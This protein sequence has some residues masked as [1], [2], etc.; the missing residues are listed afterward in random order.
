MNEVIIGIQVVLEGIRVDDVTWVKPI[1]KEK[2]NV[3]ILENTDKTT[4]HQNG[5]VRSDMGLV[6]QTS[7]GATRVVGDGSQKF[8]I[9]QITTSST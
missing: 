7:L 8:P 4:E 5:E 9:T 3:R 1:R 2:L 6:Q